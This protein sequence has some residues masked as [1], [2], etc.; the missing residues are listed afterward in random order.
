M[1]QLR[2]TNTITLAHATELAAKV[3]LS[4][5]GNEIATT[6]N[7]QVQSDREIKEAVVAKLQ[8]AILSAKKVEGV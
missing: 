8:A 7:G 2:D 5:A 4:V 6:I 1:G 3:I